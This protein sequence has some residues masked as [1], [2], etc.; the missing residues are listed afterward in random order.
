M[1]PG[2]YLYTCT[3]VRVYACSTVMRVMRVVL[4]DVYKKLA[5][6]HARLAMRVETNIMPSDL[7]CS[8]SF[9]FL[10]S[11]FLSSVSLLSLFF[12]SSFSLLSFLSQGRGSADTGRLLEHEEC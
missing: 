6:Q 12:L 8:S 3:R 11:F 7:L 5:S 2:G 9:H 1:S 10:G 4:A